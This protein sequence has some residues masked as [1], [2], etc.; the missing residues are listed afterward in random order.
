LQTGLRFEAGLKLKFLKLLL[1][2]FIFAMFS[3]A[4][5][6]GKL[7]VRCLEI[8]LRRTHGFD[9][10]IRVVRMTTKIE[11]FLDFSK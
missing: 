2:F 3:K 1:I 8:R 6:A 10:R 11:M 9:I 7:S 4:C 5:Q